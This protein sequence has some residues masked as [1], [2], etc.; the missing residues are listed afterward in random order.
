VYHYAECS[1]VKAIKAHGNAI[2]YSAKPA[3]KRLHKGCPQ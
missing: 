1:I 2:T 3:N